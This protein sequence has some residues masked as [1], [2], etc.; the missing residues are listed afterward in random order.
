MDW[1]FFRK[2]DIRAFIP[3]YFKDSGEMTKV[4]TA[5]GEKHVMPITIRTFRS[6]LC[7]FYSIDYCSFRRKYG[8]IIGSTN[9]VPLAISSNK[10]FLQLKVRTPMFRNDSAMAYVDLYSIERLEKQKDKKGTDVILKDGYKLEILYSLATVKKH[11][12]NANLVL[13]HYR[14]EKGMIEY[15]EML[16]K[17][18]SN[19]N[20]PATKGDIVLLA[21]EILSI[22][23]CLN[24]NGDRN[25]LAPVNIY[26]SQGC[27]NKI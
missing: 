7:R 10:V 5:E 25:N 23:N 13:E 11:M 1:N 21:S 24:L 27:E 3:I 6:N 4:I 8:Q 26:G 18:Y 20:K 12:N 19:L 2:Y 14:K 9:C 15:P 22:K 17:L 16:E